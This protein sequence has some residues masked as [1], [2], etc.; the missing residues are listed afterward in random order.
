MLSLVGSSHKRTK[1]VNINHVEQG[2]A[3][4]LVNEKAHAKNQRTNCGSI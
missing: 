2:N 4:M 1:A 3:E